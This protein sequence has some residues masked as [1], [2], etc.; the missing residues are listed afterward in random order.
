MAEFG[1][2]SFSNLL[3]LESR[4]LSTRESLKVHDLHDAN[5]AGFAM[6]VRGTKFVVSMVAVFY[7]S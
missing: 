2:F 5:Q 3:D 1:S 6:E 4:E 7:P